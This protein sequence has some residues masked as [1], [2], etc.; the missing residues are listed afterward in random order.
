MGDECSI[1]G[2]RRTV[3]WHFHVTSGLDGKFET[4]KRDLALVPATGKR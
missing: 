1:F 2:A 3:S 4:A